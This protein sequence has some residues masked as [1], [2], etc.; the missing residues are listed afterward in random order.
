MELLTS[1]QMREA[2]RVAIH[3]MKIPGL[4]LMENAGR[5]AAAEI[6]RLLKKSFRRPIAV[7]CGKGNNG[8]DGIVIA[9]VLAR[10]GIRVRVFLLSEDL[11]PDA[12]AQLRRLP[13]SRVERIRTCNLTQWKKARSR[14]DDC[15]LI[16]DAIFGTGM[17]GKLKDPYPAI[18][19]DIN[20]TG[21]PIVAVDIPSGID[22]SSGAI[23]GA[24]I[25]AHTTVAFARPKVGHIMPPGA[26]CTGRLIVADIG[27]PDEAVTRSRPD[28]FLQA[29][30]AS[31]PSLPSRPA[32][33]HKG[34]YGRTVILAGSRGMIG[35]A[36]LA[37]E[38]AMRIGAGLTTLAIP[39]SVYA[40]AAR[41]LSPEAMCRP[42]PDGGRGFFS[43]MSSREIKPIV[44][45]STAVVLGPG[46]G[47]DS[48]TIRWT[49]D[50]LKFLPGSGHVVID[51]DA[52]YALAVTGCPK[53]FT[54][55]DA[56]L[57]P[58]AGE[59]AALT[60]QTRS[61]VESNAVAIARAFASHHGVTVVLKGS[62]TVIAVPEGSV[63]VNIT[64]NSALAKGGSGDVLAGMIGGLCAQ[65]LSANHS[66]RLAVYLHGRAADLLVDSGRDKRT[67]IA[68]D[69]FQKFDKALRELEGVPI[70]A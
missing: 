1:K 47:R 16:V 29:R 9:R 39:D 59:M 33:S 18:I 57:T 28:T 2:D 10:R 58:H 45:R 20:R 34:S 6:V 12:A 43:K 42:V 63:F 3:D 22:A 41:K 69:L 8:G 52:L 24:A 44:E 26:S 64:G 53:G 46:I 15:A 70:T 55:A 67:V 54:K 56:V 36:V 49:M 60:G 17:S 61:R 7:V 37:A 4:T 48:R 65:G 11:S 5:A 27:I 50:V 62:R 35:A 13:K 40:I 25:R 51:A 23:L 38:A 19:E 68:S 31:I 30:R 14:L 21:N 32:H 66:A